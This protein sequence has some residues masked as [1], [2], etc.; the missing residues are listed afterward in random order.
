MLSIAIQYNIIL[1]MWTPLVEPGNE[2]S[3]NVRII[4][5]NYSYYQ[6]TAPDGYISG[7]A[8]GITG[9]CSTRRV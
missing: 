1:P 4:S 3:C 2:V 9:L 7:R 5:L 8:S 6:P